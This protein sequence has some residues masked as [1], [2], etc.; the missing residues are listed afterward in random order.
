MNLGCVKHFAYH[1]FLE[2]LI[3]NVNSYHLK[4]DTSLQSAYSTGFLCVF[5]YKQ[6]QDCL[7]PVS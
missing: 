6:G 2:K 4:E 3:G 1:L 5:F 7:K